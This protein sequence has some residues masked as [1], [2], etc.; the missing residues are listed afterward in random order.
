MSTQD[1]Q[2]GRITAILSSVSSSLGMDL[3]VDEIQEEVNCIKKFVVVGLLAAVF[4]TVV[5]YGGVEFMGINYLL[6]SVVAIELAILG[7]YFINN[8][9]TF[10]GHTHTNWR[11]KISGLMKTNLIRG[12][13]IPLQV[14]LLFI[15]SHS[16]G[17]FYIFANICAMGVAGVYRY[18]L[19]SRWTW[20][21]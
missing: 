15:V 11:D 17:I 6:V 8:Q 3:D 14:G 7:Q 20:A 10:E 4:E 19:D 2:G 12:T 1:I 13:S 18:V 16:L 5:L 9:W 21:R